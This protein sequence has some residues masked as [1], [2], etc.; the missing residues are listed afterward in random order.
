MPAAKTKPKGPWIIM[1]DFAAHFGVSYMT[2]LR[3]VQEGR[4]PH[5]K[6]GRLNFEGGR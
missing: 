5:I 6:V 1:E 3:L 2:V 4:I